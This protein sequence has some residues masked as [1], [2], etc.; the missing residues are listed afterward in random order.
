MTKNA[1]AKASASAA[2]TT[3]SRSAKRSSIC[4]TAS[5]CAAAGAVARRRAA[6]AQDHGARRPVSSEAIHRQAD[7]QDRCRADP[8]GAECETRARARRGTA[9]PPH[10]AVARPPA[11][12][13]CG[14]IERLA[15][16]V[17]GIDV[18]PVTDLVERARAEQPTG[19]STGAS[20]ALF[21]CCA[22]HSGSKQVS[23]NPRMKPLVGIIMGRSRIGTR[24]SPPPTRCSASAS[25][26]TRVVCAASHAG[27]VVRVRRHC[28]RTAS[29]S[30][31]PVPVARRICPA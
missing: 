13:R 29:K 22:R 25:H 5:R 27:F 12:G 10:R 18:A 3:C 14:A 8:R 23:Y 31:S 15:A 30:S 21:A 26:E 9:L 24:S 11:A 19:D 20:R 28:A 7:A 6:R 16:E 17:P 1:P 2:A 4:R